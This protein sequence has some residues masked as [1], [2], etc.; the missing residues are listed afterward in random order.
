MPLSDRD[1]VRPSSPRRGNWGGRSFNNLAINPIFAI[2]AANLIVFLATIINSDLIT[3]LGLAPSLF[4]E[5]P[6]TIVTNM[7]VHG[8]FWHLFGNMITLFFFGRV[9][10]KMMGGWRF[11]LVYFCG[12]L[13]GNLLYLLL[14]DPMTIAIGASGAVY[15]LAGALVILMP[16]MKVFLWFIVPM[17]LWVVVLVFFVIWSFI[18]GV[19]WQAHLGGLAVGLISGFIFKRQMRYIIYR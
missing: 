1:Y 11:L 18:P 2:I 12:G 15:A 6:W 8:G 10:Y 19:A 16:K 14:G 17:P 5:R 7:F 4:T 9:V 13:A 3:M